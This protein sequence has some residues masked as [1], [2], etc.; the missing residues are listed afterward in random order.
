L[1]S[2]SLLRKYGIK[3]YDVRLSWVFDENA[4]AA[5]VNGMHKR[6]ISA[7]VNAPPRLNLIGA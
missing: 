3:E 5:A 1:F 7:G 4:L 2:E 6:Q